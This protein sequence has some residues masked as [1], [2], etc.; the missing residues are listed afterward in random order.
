MNTFDLPILLASTS[1]RRRYLMEQVRL[2][3]EVE[4]PSTDETP[5]PRE[6][7]E[8]LVSRLARDKAE[9]IEGIAQQKYADCLIV[10]A[11][12]IVVAPDGKK[13]LGKPRDEKDAIK[14][15]KLLAGKTHLVLTGYCVLRVSPLAPTRRIVRV[16]K[17]KVQ[18]RELSRDAILRY[19]ASGE[20]MDK[21]G[22]YGAQGLG[23]GLVEKI[24]GS[25]TNV[26][27]LPMAQL[28]KDIEKLGQTTLW[29]WL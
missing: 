1:P 13:I 21:A 7:P 8:K 29:Q 6:K 10:A 17:S 20:P 26:V 15:L 23:M 22:S 28:L 16:V 18:M 11:D 9:S 24:S 19:V 4:S 27:G 12:T 5:R 2:S 25:Y 3:V 14:M